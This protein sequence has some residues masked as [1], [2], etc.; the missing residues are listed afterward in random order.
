[1]DRRR[2][3]IIATSWGFVAGVLC[4]VLGR[5]WL[6]IDISLTYLLLLLS[7]RML[8]GFVIGI[9]A[10]RWHWALHGIVLGLIVG[11]PDYHFRYMILGN[12]NS[13][14]YFLFGPI[15]GLMIEFFTSVVFKARQGQT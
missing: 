5:Y 13:G 1:M 12:L 4:Y 11:I 6:G 9:S 7:H 10:L 15:W 8:L 3:V 2:R 14:I